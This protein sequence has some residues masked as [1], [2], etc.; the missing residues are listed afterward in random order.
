M[1]KRLF[2]VTIVATALFS[3]TYCAS[4]DTQSDYQLA[5]QEYQTA[6]TNW[7]LEIK[8]KQ[9]NFKTAM[10][11]WNVAI[12][13]A[14]QA[15]KEIASQFKSDAHAVTART[16]AAVTAAVTAKEKKAAYA[17]GKI[18]LDLAIALRNTALA[19]VVKPGVKPAKP[20]LLPAP[21]PPAPPAKS[22][23]APK[24]MKPSEKPIV[25]KSPKP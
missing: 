5:L 9:E 13:A 1:K 6:L 25:T 4:A 3:P 19:A 8:A 14:E 17:V 22:A 18:E 11:D 15:R 21:T 16:M 23:K 12:K 24:P 7:N 2:L 10:L 20:M